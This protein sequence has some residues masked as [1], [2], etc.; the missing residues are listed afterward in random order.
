MLAEVL[1]VEAVVEI[2]EFTAD[3]VSCFSSYL[4]SKKCVMSC[5]KENDRWI[6]FD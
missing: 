4:I 1:A 6:N 5:S 3:A 2:M